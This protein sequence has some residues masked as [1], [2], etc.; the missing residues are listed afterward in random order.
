MT[1]KGPSARPGSSSS[2]SRRRTWL[3]PYIYSTP[4]PTSAP[5]H[6][7]ILYVPTTAH[8]NAWSSSD[9]SS[10]R[11]QVELIFRGVDFNL[12]QIDLS[13]WWPTTCPALHAPSEEGPERWID[14]VDISAWAQARHPSKFEQSSQSSD[15]PFPYRTVDTHNQAK[16]YTTLVEKAL[17]PA[18][19]LIQLERDQRLQAQPSSSRGPFFASLWDRYISSQRTNQQA[20]KI[21]NLCTSSSVQSGSFSRWTQWIPSFASGIN[22][23]WTST[24]QFL[25]ATPSAKSLRVTGPLA[26]ATADEHISYPHDLDPDHVID[27]AVETIETLARDFHTN[28]HNYQWFMGATEPTAIDALLFACFHSILASDDEVLRG[29]VLEHRHLVR[30]TQNVYD[31][32][33][34]PKEI[35]WRNGKGRAGKVH[36]WDFD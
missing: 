14:D 23:A 18:V 34:K 3:P 12:D 17:L 7:P 35:Q 16:L 32:H 6:H 13:Q 10:L 22:V 25:T 29:A 26:A 8:H 20:Q 11:T 19:L 2:N 15:D 9:V 21:H 4:R 30:W 27:Q 1:S 28:A 24:E 33:V 31:L 36:R 5:I